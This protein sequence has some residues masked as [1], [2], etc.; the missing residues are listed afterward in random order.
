[1]AV[2]RVFLSYTHRNADVADVVDAAWTAAGL[3]LVRDTHAVQP[4]GNFV[5]Y[6]KDALDTADYCLLLWSQAA[7][8]SGW[9][10]EEWQVALKRTVEEKR[11]FLLIGRVE[12]YPLPQILSVR[13]YVDLFPTP[14]PGVERLIATVQADQTADGQTDKPV[15]PAAVPSN[16]ASTGRSEIYVTSTRWDIT[17]PMPVDLHAPAGVVVQRIRQD[18][19]LPTVVQSGRHEVARFAYQL[20]HAGQPLEDGQ[21]LAEAGV[22]PQHVLRLLT[23]QTVPEGQGRTD[24]R[25]LRSPDDIHSTGPATDEE[26]LVAKTLQRALARSGLTEVPARRRRSH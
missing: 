8:N 7:A 24:H 19:E 1:M 6:M 2:P 12:D 10:T 17:V 4:G 14:G 23:H 25:V 26:V 13:L 3:S 15:V 21:T 22:Q 9:V 18:L 11:N 16:L 5:A 20:E